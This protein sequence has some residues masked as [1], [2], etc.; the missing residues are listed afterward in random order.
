MRNATKEKEER[1]EGIESKFQDE[2]SEIGF[3]QVG[4]RLQ[5]TISTARKWGNAHGAPVIKLI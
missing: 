3:P 5:V 2:N 4:R 1:K